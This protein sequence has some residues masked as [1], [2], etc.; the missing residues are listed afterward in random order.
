MKSEIQEG[1]GYCIVYSA[2]VKYPLV[3]RNSYLH[4]DTTCHIEYFWNH[5][6]DA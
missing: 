6:M 2:R 1:A 4:V 5:R 3:T